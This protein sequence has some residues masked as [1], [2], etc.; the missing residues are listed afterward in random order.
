MLGSPV[1]ARL[2]QT[3]AVADYF[4]DFAQPDILESHG[5]WTR[6]YCDN[7]FR[8][9]RFSALYRPISASITADAW[10]DQPLPQKVIWIR[11]TIEIGHEG[12]ERKLHDIAKIELNEK[13]IKAELNSCDATQT[14]CRYILRTVFRF[15]PE[16]LETGRFEEVLSLFTHELD[17]AY[18]TAW[19]ANDSV[20]TIFQHFVAGCRTDSACN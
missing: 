13:T 6:L 11:R 1:M 17:R 9:P 10:C 4:L 15:I 18:L 16:L 12:R 19:R 3:P 2:G 14:D 5:Y 7:L 8:N 20:D